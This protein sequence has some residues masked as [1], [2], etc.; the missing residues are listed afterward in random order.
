M[1][2]RAIEVLYTLNGHTIRTLSDGRK[3]VFLPVS[4]PHSNERLQKACEKMIGANRKDL[5]AQ[6]GGWLLPLDCIVAGIAE[7]MEKSGVASELRK[8]SS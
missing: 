3:A 7:Q 2:V 1:D 5:I 6:T 8:A 4:N